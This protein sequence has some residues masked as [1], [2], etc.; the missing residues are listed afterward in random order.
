ML[1]LLLG[2]NSI[3]DNMAK[4]IYNKIIPFNGFTAITIWPLI[5]ARREKEPISDVTINHESTHLKQQEEML[6]LPF[7]LWYLI[8]WLI[9][10]I[11][12]WN[13]TEAYRNI[14]FEQEAYINQ[15]DMHYLDNRK[16]YGWLR[17]VG[18]KTY[19]IIK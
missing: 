12:Y 15:R 11:I 5:F 2:F 8:E 18:K 16:R 7:F 9:R 10:F 13:K 17:Y 6:V 4:I 1:V 14:S 19:R 3:V